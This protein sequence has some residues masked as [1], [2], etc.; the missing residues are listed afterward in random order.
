MPHISMKIL[1]IVTLFI[2][3]AAVNAYAQASAPVKI[4]F[5]SDSKRID[6]LTEKNLTDYKEAEKGSFRFFTGRLDE[7]DTAVYYFHDGRRS[8][9]K[10]NLRSMEKFNRKYAQWKLRYTSGRREVPQYI[11]RIHTLAVSFIPLN[12]STGKPEP[13]VHIMLDDLKLI[14]WG[15]K[16]P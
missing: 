4:E 11:P 2:T 14:D 5:E 6:L 9:D 13:R 10:K 16:K 3:G 12:P 15:E 8:V 7:P 1:M